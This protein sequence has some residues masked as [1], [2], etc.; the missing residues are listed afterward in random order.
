MQ[1]IWKGGVTKV[2]ATQSN[3]GCVLHNPTRI[4]VPISL[5][6]VVLLRLEIAPPSQRTENPIQSALL[7]LCMYRDGEVFLGV[8][9]EFDE[10]FLHPVPSA[11][12]GA[13]QED[14]QPLE[15]L[16]K[17]DRWGYFEKFEATEM[18]LRW[19]FVAR[20]RGDEGE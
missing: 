13:G 7:G 20:G 5:L 10:E 1:V 14:E 17:V 8:I 6:P 11:G 19:V 9:V 15:A 18:A 2:E 3:L 12:A 4:P 16:R